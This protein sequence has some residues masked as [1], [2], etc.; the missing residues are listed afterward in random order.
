MSAAKV[1]E[2]TVELSRHF[3]P[4]SLDSSLEEATAS[5]RRERAFSPWAPW[6]GFGVGVVTGLLVFGKK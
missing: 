6:L 1:I 2:G 3:A 5:L 4:L